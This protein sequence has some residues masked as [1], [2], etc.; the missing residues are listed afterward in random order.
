MTAEIFAPGIISTCFNE[1]G[2]S[3]SPDG[4]ELYYRILGPPRGA[5]YYMKERQNG[6]WTKPM[7]APF[8]E[9]YDAK[10]IEDLKPEELK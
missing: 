9:K 10:I 2:I 3:F 1:H 8:L 6:N 5:I 7:I 4:K